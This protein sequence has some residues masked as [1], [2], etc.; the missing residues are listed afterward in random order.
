LRTKE[1][2]SRLKIQVESLTQ[3]ILDLREELKQQ[4]IALSSE[5]IEKAYK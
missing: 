4:E 5:D 3:T 1:D 2:N